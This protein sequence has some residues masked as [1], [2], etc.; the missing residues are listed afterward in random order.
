MDDKSRCFMTMVSADSYQAYILPYIMALRTWSDD[1]IVVFVRGELKQRTR[2]AIALGEFKGVEVVEK[3]AAMNLPEN[4]ST[5]NCLR[6]LKGSEYLKENMFT[7]I[8]DADM[9]IL[10]DPWLWHFEKLRG[11]N[12]IAGHHGAWNKP[13]RPEVCPKWD[14][15]FERTAGGMVCV[16]F[17]WWERTLAARRKYYDRL[18]S[19]M[20]GLYREA[21]EV[22]LTHIIKESDMEV[23]ISKDFPA[24]LRGLHFGDFKFQH[25]VE[26][27]PKMKTLLS[28]ITVEKYMALKSSRKWKLVIGELN[29]MELND[30]LNKVDT[31]LGE[32]R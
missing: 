14:G 17:D 21:D 29:S 10:N 1:R 26:N 23:P 24:D 20:E 31:Y 16:R 8:T 5:T 15:A 4:I 30:I 11:T 22:M 2:N 28:N 27:M 13:N 32:R 6:F 7:M 9:A 3:Y 19:G 12:A 25:R 18:E